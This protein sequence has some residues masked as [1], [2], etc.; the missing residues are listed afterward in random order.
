MP[1]HQWGPFLEGG[2]QEEDAKI[3]PG[4]PKEACTKTGIGGPK[5]VTVVISILLLL[6][7]LLLTIFSLQNSPPSID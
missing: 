7:L 1:C 4:P 2:S 6:L 5:F 3:L